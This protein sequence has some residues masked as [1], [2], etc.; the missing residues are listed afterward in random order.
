MAVQDLEQFKQWDEASGKAALRRL[1]FDRVKEKYP[2]THILYRHAK[3]EL[4]KAEA[5]L[6]AVQSTL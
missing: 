3:S 4:E 1:V 2:E 6:D 5:H